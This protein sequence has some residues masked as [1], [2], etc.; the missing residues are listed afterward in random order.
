MKRFI[1]YIA[2]IALCITFTQ[3]KKDFLNATSPSN[4]DDNFVTATPSE[5]F[6][7]LSWCY[8]NY[9]QNCIMGTYRWNDPIGSD[10]ET[11]PE[12]NSSNNLDAILRP[13]Q[14][15]IDAVA[16][17]FNGLYGTLARASKVA[18]LI[19]AKDVYKK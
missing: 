6:K 3:C 17:G 9:R 8:A 1:N 12:E 13:D 11:Y 4:V 15:P 16:A 2:I 18:G 19:A 10:A 7:T 14:L 5:T